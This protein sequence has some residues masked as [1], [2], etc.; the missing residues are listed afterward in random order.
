MADIVLVQPVVGLLDN[1]KSAPAVPLSLL[2]TASLVCK[3]FE[4]KIIDQRTDV[5][6]QDLLRQEIKKNPLCIGVTSMLGPQIKFALEILKVVKTEDP[7]VKTVWG[8]ASA[9]S[10]PEDTLKHNLV[11]VVIKGDGEI[12]FYE[13]VKTLKN[14]ESLKNVDGIYYKENGNIVATGPRKNLPLDDYPDV[15]YNLVDVKRYL[16]LRFGKPTIDMETSRGCPFNCTFCYNPN[17]SNRNWR[18]LSADKLITRVKKLAKEY[19][20]DSFWFIDDELFI[21][22]ERAKKIIIAMNE[23]NFKWTVQGT[24]VKSALRMDKE[25]LKML[26][27]SGCEQMNL[28]AESGS[29]RILKMID[30][31]ITIEDIIEVNNRFKGLSI[32]PWYYFVVGYPSE[33][34]DEIKMTSDLIIKLLSENENAKISGIGCYTPYPGTKLFEESKKIGYISPEQLEGWSTYSVDNINIP[35]I[36]G[37]MKQIVEGLQFTSFFVDSKPR[38]IAAPWYVQVVWYFYQYIARWRMKKFNFSVPFEIILGNKIKN[39]IGV[40]S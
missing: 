30:K 8:G 37:K 26:A 34:I 32:A 28:G 12:T 4:V 23:L 17:V 18:A 3:E 11:D 29:N 20:I 39:K 2:H 15:P 1:I 27:K 36:K 13:L 31:G 40:R 38:D 21:D 24:T 6:W 25:Y 19:N 9:S 14:K 10:M 5:N 16:P 22:L 7:K 33:T 35:W